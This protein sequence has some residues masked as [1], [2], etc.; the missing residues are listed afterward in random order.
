[1]TKGY[2][3]VA[4]EPDPHLVRLI[5]Q[6]FGREIRQR[7]LTLLEVAVG[8]REGIAQFWLCDHVSEWNSLDRSNAAQLEMT[9][10]PIEVYCRPFRGIL[11]DHGVPYY[12]KVDI[13]SSD[14]YCVEAIDAW[15]AP[16]F[17]SVE[18]S[19]VDDLVALAGAGY[20]Q[21]KLIH[22]GRPYRHRQFD[23]TPQFDPT[24]SGSDRSGVSAV[25]IR[26]GPSGPFG[27]DTDGEWHSFADTEDAV[28]SFF[29]GHSQYG[30]PPDWFVWFDIHATKP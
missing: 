29:G 21:F 15:D 23:P 10:H 19:G 5:R 18:L 1:L 25:S 12:L 8:P 11:R 27:E 17:V 4:I 13:E 7:A 16:Q 28:R 22:Q 6:R 9:H 26:P 2:R 20:T 30:N 14:H 24:R 3:V